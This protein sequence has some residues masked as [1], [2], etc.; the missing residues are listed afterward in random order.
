[1][2]PFNLGVRAHD[3][4]ADN[5]EVLANKLKKFGLRHTQLAVRKSFGKIFPSV[6]SFSPGSARWI[7]ESLKEQ[8]V[9]ISILGC[10]VNISSENLE[11]R[12]KAIEDFKIHLSL[13]REFGAL[14]VGTETGSIKGGYCKENF[15]EDAYQITV[16][17]VA[18]MVE[19]AEKMGVLVAIEPG[20]NHPIFSAQRLKR[21]TDD[22][23]SDNLK[24]II[25]CSNLITPENFVNHKDVAKEAIH[26]LG[27]KIMH[28][29][30]KDC[31]FEDGIITPVPFGIG[32]LDYSPIFEFAKYEK[33][34]ISM[35]FEATEEKY[36][37]TAIEKAVEL[38]SRV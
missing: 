18:E 4:D 5:P 14:A 19:Y 12:Q 6:N 17:S 13:C 28:F 26:L 33:P 31:I 35:T 34:F 10:Y 16:K 30:I 3:V 1:M 38:Y 22:I 36:L 23:K 24:V 21:L 7:N 27:D 37:S 25:D 8:D 2:I 15:T 11:V 20:L 9:Y 32:K 29:H